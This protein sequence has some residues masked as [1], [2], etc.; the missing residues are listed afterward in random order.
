MDAVRERL[1]GEYE[2]IV[3]LA[4][5][6]GV[7]PSISDPIGYQEVHVRGTQNLLKLARE[8]G[9]KQFVFASSSSIYGINPNVPWRETTAC[10]YP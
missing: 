4:A 6:A 3:H 5:K 1:S 7:R 9:V 8:W 2:V 10:F